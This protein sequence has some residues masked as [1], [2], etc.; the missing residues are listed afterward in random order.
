MVLTDLKE[1]EGLIG[2]HKNKSVSPV[3]KIKEYNYPVSWFPGKKT[4]DAWVLLI[5]DS[6]I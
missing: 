4:A 1:E 6:E 3:S 5:T 2:D